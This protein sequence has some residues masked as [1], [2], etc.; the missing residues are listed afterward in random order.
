VS[1]RWNVDPARTLLTGMSD[2]GT[3]TLLSGLADGAPFT[4]LAPVAASFHPFLLSMTSPARLTGLPI[5]LTHGAL[6]WM[7]PVSQARTANQVLQAAGAAVTYR[8]I[9]DLS[10]AYPRDRQSEVL[11]WWI[12]PA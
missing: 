11:D 12:T 2:G 7:F 3:F 5:H 4:H 10:H 6:D 1:A 9:P 8:E